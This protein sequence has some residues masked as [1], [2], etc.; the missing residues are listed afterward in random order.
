MPAA[1]LL[2]KFKNGRV[3]ECFESHRCVAFFFDMDIYKHLAVR[4]EGAGAGGQKLR[5]AQGFAIHLPRLTTALT[6][7]PATSAPFPPLRHTPSPCRTP[8][9]PLTQDEMKLEGVSSSVA[10][11]TA[12]FHTHMVR[13]ACANTP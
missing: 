8:H 5:R 2:L 11:S 13:P 10:A 12:R 4:L 6:T 9:R 1:R 7:V 3:E